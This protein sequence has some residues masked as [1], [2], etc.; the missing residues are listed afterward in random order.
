MGVVN[1]AT[2]L[3]WFEAGRAHYMR[4]RDCSYSRIEQEGIQLPVVE[5][6]LTYLKPARYDDL[7]AV[8]S[9]LGDLGRVQLR[10]DYVIE[11]DGEELVRGF[12]RHAAVGRAGRITRLPDGVRAALLAP[13]RDQ[14]DEGSGNGRR[15]IRPAAT[16]RD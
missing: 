6:G 10:F 11:R 14:G 2:Y 12:T 15:L 4:T 5:A 3:R 8:R 16:W 7:L 1:H 9:W 13:E